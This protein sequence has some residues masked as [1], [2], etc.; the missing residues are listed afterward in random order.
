MST[1]LI[2]TLARQ[3]N[4]K[5]EQNHI[6]ELSGG[7]SSQAYKVDVAGEPFVLL[8]QREGAVSQSNYGHTY[9]VLTL[10]QRHG[11]THA[12]QPLWLKDD[13]AAL[14]ISFYE[15]IASDAFDF[16]QTGIN[17]EQLAIAVMDSLL[18]AAEVAMDEYKQLAAEL[19]VTPLPVKTPGKAA[20]EYGT[21]WLQ[22][23]TQS[24][25][26]PDI[27]AWLEP[28]V[29]CSVAMAEQFGNNKSLF[30]HGDPS[31]PNILLG[32]DGS[33]MLIDWDSARFQTTGPEFYV[34]YTT[35][36]TDFMKPYRQ[37][38]IAH[39]AH[40]LNIPEE[41]LTSRVHEFRRFTEVF[42]VN[43][44]AMMMAKVSTGE[45]TGDVSHFR[46]IALERMRI[47]EQ[48]FEQ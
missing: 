25:P 19:N 39:V 28:R 45:I 26:D 34:A 12:P 3:V 33:F 8:V 23:V 35:H 38:L 13:H 21:E 36:L 30:G 5:V 43:W 9:V 10:L 1:N 46:A 27:V 17:S 29:Q 41:E 16:E 15:G 14:A 31:N 18:D 40:R 24:C 48:S 11:F 47:Y 32:A 7:F 22:I 37:T 6:S 44:A 4:S 2:L 42:D 20:A